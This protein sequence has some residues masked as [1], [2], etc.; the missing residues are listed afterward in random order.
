MSHQGDRGA[1]A[2][3]IV[4]AG[5]AEKSNGSDGGHPRYEPPAIVWREP[6]EPLSF[7][8]SCAKQPGNPG[9]NP[10]PFSS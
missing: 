1:K 3:S 6:Y 2:G 7:G 5:A 8:I 10:G 4:D 9:C